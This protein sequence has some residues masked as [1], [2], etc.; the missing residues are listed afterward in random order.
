MKSIILGDLHFGMKG[1]N[2]KFFD[3]QLKFFHEQLFPFMIEND[4]TEIIQLGDWLDNR[5]NMDIKFFNRIVNEFLKPMKEFG[6]HFTTFLGNH[7]IYY[8]S[9]LEVNLVKYFEDLFPQNVTV[10]S[11]RV[12]QTYG[13][14]TYM[15]VP[16][17]TDK[18]VSLP[19]LR[20]V[21]VLFGHFEI[22]NFEM[23]KG[24]KDEKSSLTTD[25]F[26]KAPQLKRVVS[27]HYHVQGN[28]GF[29]MYVGTPYQLNWGDYQTER[30]FFVFEG[31]DF[32]FY[33]N[34]ASPKYVKIK[35]DDTNDFPIEIS[36]LTSEPIFLSEISQ[37]FE[38]GSDL[39]DHKIKFF[40]NCAKDKEYESVIFFLHQ[41][42]VEMDIINNVEISDLI[43]TD[44]VGEIDNIGGTELVIR[45][46]KENKPHLIPLLNEIIQEITKD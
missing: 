14:M 9:T 5:K 10:H 2:D 13:D 25:Y 21:D 39:A 31:A 38:E 33:E 16:W 36:G 1:F 26:K 43:G 44:F 37:A 17:V 22:K 6:I 28:D 12:K 23:V 27:G 35:Y 42:G 40:I 20:D 30:G 45:S 8:N 15:F 19:E 29:V 4:I 41:K 11:S 34:L 32:K 18:G 24:H 46:V 7:D 3:T